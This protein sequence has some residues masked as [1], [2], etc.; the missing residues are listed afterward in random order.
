ML[1][2]GYVA[3]EPDMPFTPA[4]ALDLPLLGVRAPV[5]PETGA[6]LPKRPLPVAG[7]VQSTLGKK[8]MALV[9]VEVLVAPDGAPN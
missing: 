8:L 9:G 4:P 2:E 1:F 7:G 5:T 3:L 6:G